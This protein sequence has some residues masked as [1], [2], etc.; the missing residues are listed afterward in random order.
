MATDY[1]LDVYCD[2]DLRPDMPKVSG[3]SLLIQRVRNGLET[4]PGT[5][6]WDPQGVG[7]GYDIRL[8]INAKVRGDLRSEE[9][10]IANQIERDDEVEK[11]EVEITTQTDGKLLVKCRI[12]DAAGPFALTLSVDQLTVD[13]IN[14]GA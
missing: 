3:R 10:R 8:L 11:A 12:W 6:D 5:M 9:Q 1:G 14:E 4:A 2:G 7:W 13:I